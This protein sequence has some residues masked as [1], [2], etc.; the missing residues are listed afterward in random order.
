MGRAE[1][2]ELI[3]K[4][5]AAR[6]SRVICYLTSDREG[7]EAQVVKDVLPLFFEHMRQFGESERIDLLLYTAGGDTLAAFGIARLL[8]EF[9]SH[10]GVL[11]PA[12]CH[13]AGTLLAL[14]ANQIVMTKG[15]H[16][17][18][19]DPSVSGPLNPAIQVPSQ[20]AAQIVPLSVESVAGFKDLVMSEWGIKG[21]EALGEAFRALTDKVHPLALGDVYRARQQIELLARKLLL[22]HRHDDDNL[23][24]IVKTLTRGLGSHDYLILRTEARELLGAQ[25]ATDDDVLEGLVWDLY[26]DFA[27]EMQLRS[28]HDVLGISQGFKGQPIPVVLR[29][30]MVESTAMTDVAERHLAIS[31]LTPQL[32]PGMP[33]QG[34]QI[35]ARAIQHEIVKSGWFRYA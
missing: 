26:R 6:K 9:G 32:P 2:V 19:I 7:A 21:E 22:S 15:A 23:S 33:I 3:K 31:V 34:F 13:S 12:R 25:V 24:T 20:Q 4:I 17:S 11:V 16:L 8:R 1:R 29:F 28:A 5:E 18:P 27:E 14:G 30:A 10:I 35:P